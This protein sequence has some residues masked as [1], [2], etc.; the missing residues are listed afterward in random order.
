MR[1]LADHAAH[2]RRV[3]E[4]PLLADLVEPEPDQGRPLVRGAARRGRALCCALAIGLAATIA[5]AAEDEIFDRVERALSWSSATGTLRGHVSGLLDLEGYAF[6]AP[7]PAL[8]EAGGHGLFA[9]RL[10]TFLDAQFGARVYVF[11]QARVDRGFDPANAPLRARLD[12]YAVR[13][14]PSREAHV[15]VQVGKFATVVGS[16]VVLHSSWTNG[17]ISAP[18]V[19]ENLTG[20]WD[21]EAV[22]ATN[23]L[24]QWSHLRPGL[25]A[26]VTAHEKRLRVPV[27]WGPGYALGAAVSGRAGTLH[28]AAEVKQ[29]PL[30]SR[31]EVWSRG[32]GLA[33]HPTVSGRVGW[34]PSQMWDIGFSASS[35]AYLRPDFPQS[36]APGHGRG[37]YREIVLGQ[38]VSFAWHHV[39]VWTEIFAAR[40]RIPLVGDADTAAYYAEARYKFTPQLSGAVRWNQQFFGR[41][42]ER[43]A[44]VPWGED[45]SRLDLAPTYRF[46]PHVQARLQYSWQHGAAGPRAAA[47]LVMG[48]L[49]VRF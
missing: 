4:G 22:R 37:D 28:Y 5:R 45:A 42:P 34:R 44:R 38:D 1:D 20:I 16:W 7:A 48:Q 40:Y 24:L 33:D 31:P 29:A 25:P 12:E 41:V 26:A 35:G 43:G 10:T 13:Y 21:S 19:Y 17:F 23:T 32:K 49:T 6:P 3:H 18:L 46:S 11:A 36:L 15:S 30:S 14:T 9:P 2:F 47:H 39:Q 8:I 27:I